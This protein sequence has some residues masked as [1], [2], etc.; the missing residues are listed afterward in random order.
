MRK[1][2]EN[3]LVDNLYLC[4]KKTQHND[5]T[6]VQKQITEKLGPKK[7]FVAPKKLILPKSFKRKPFSIKWVLSV[8]KNYWKK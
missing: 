7:E 1:G 8:I 3:N 4:I 5:P 6:R 2:S